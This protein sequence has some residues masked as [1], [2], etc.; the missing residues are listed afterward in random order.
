MIDFFKEEE[1]EPGMST[2]DKIVIGS[3]ALGV[4]IMVIGALIYSRGVIQIGG[5][6]IIIG[7]ITAVLP[8]GIISFLKNRAVTEMERQ[9]PAFLKDLAESKRGGM[10][11]LDSFES[12]KETDY[13]R[14]NK[15]IEK[16]QSQLSWGIPFPEVIERFS[17]RMKAS[18]VIQ[19]SLSIM[20]QSYK[21][22]G[23][24]TKTIESVGE[25][26][27]MLKE[28]IQKKNSML[29]QQLVIMYVIYFLF[30][31]ITVGIYFLMA[32]L[33]GLGTPETGTLE[34]V[35][36][37][38]GD[39]DDAEIDN[40]C[41]P[42]VPYA[43]PLCGIAQIFGFVPSNVTDFTS[44]FAEQYSYGQMAYYKSIL[45]TMLMIQGMSSAAVAG[46]ISEGSPSAGIKHAIIMLPAAFIVFMLVVRPMGI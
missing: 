25:S 7:V 37:F 35:G 12:A 24:I 26:A 18:P 39:G 44:D 17:K 3:V 4:L 29:K 36:E 11:M 2:E 8:Y 6:T 33:L 31:G 16:V 23:Q 20:L 38:L 45:F 41:G 30:I 34:N 9:F 5:M 15:E 27:T 42:E 19:Q 13:G 21:S 43:S 46:Q 40:F 32:Q 14:L 10:T 1:F 28:V 22:G